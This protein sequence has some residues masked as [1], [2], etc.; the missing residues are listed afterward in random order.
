MKQ[1]TWFLK[2]FGAFCFIWMLFSVADVTAAEH[3]IEQSLKVSGVVSDAQGETLPGVNVFVKGTTIGV[4]TDLDGKFSLNVPSR[5]SILVVSF[6]GYQTNEFIV[7]NTTNFKVVLEEEVNSLEEV[8]VVAYGS[9][10]KQTVTGAVTMMK[11]SE[12]LETPVA[13]V[14]NALTGKL[15]GVITQQPGGRPGEDAAE[16][17]IRGVGTWNDSK[18]L[19]II[20]GIEQ[21]SFAQ[22]DPN[23]IESLSVLKDASS[24]AVYGIRGANGVILITT[25]R[26]NMGK[27]KISLTAN[28]GLQ[29]PTS[30][31]EF[32]GSYE[33]LLLRKK[34]YE[35]DGFD[36]AAEEP[37]RLSAEALEGFRLG[38][39]PYRYPDVNWY[40]EVI[41]KKG[42]LQQQY[43]VN[44]A[45]GTKMVK[46][47]ISVGYLHQNGIF[48]YQDLQDEYDPSVYFKR[49]NFRSNIDLTINKYQTLT[50]NI[51]GRTEEMNG[52]SGAS[53]ANGGVGGFFQG[54]IAKEPWRHPIANPD[55]SIGA[56][57]G[58]TNPIAALSFGG[59]ENSKVNYYDIIGTLKND[60]SFITKGLSLDLSISFNNKYGS[61]KKYS[62]AIDTY[63]YDP[64][65]ERY[66]Q[67][68][69]DSPFAFSKE[70]N[71]SPMRRTNLQL[72]LA[73]GRKF[74]LHNVNSVLVYNQQKTTS[75]SAIPSALMGYAARVEYGYADR[76]LA[77]VSVGYNGSENFAPGHRFGVFPSGSLGY[78]ISEEPFMK[79]AKKFLPYLKIRGSVGLVG[80]DKGQ[81]R[82]LYLGQYDKVNQGSQGG[83]PS[84]GFGTTS[85]STIGGIKETRAGNENLTWET[86]LKS[87]VGIEGRLFKDNLLSF[88][89]DF[90]KEHRKNILMQLNS[91][92]TIIGVAAPY[93]NV[94]E[95]KN[96]GYEVDL[97]HRNKIGNVGYYVKGNYSF[98]RNKVI[99]KDDPVN[100]PDYQKEAGYRIGQY[101]GY[102][103]L[104]FFQSEEEIKHSPDQSTLGGPII[105]GDLKYRD[106]N[107]DNMITEEDKVPIG[108]ARI[109]EIM[110]A[111]TPGIT[112]K[113][114]EISA[115]F[116][117]AANA[118]LFF[119]GNAG[120]EFGGGAGGGQVSKTHQNYW[121]P[122]NPNP[123]Y[124][125]LH[126]NAKHSNKNIN[127]FHLKSGNY[128][129]LKNVSVAYSFPSKI[130][131]KMHMEALKI[132]LNASNLCTWSK[133]DN[134][135]PE[136]VNESGDV[137]PQQ[138]VYNL[139]ININF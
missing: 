33:H 48:K 110:Y 77:E 121:T 137:Y 122:D 13:N 55:G 45:G 2:C 1:K 73:Y 90:F 59:Y 29:V 49:F 70:T 134:F 100:K 24:T 28:W 94:G 115:M 23:E 16:I 30:V 118:S 85:P 6:V 43:N 3:S 71:I 86:A 131:K 133:I 64:I 18:P 52:I 42:S 116:Q 60:L 135:D 51:S 36:P 8:V 88:S 92:P 126:K 11:S 10:K 53:G 35:N 26:G 32:L 84:F 82:F 89:V 44:V 66:D 5:K 119:T 40:D 61:T 139:G 105:P 12:I 22:I 38:L 129:R 65:A 75:G 98:A 87:N 47:F 93:A 102:E 76:Y 108:F 54:I 127:S 19:I 9:Q 46:Y 72:K 132:Y 34:A 63:Y 4:I 17:Y 21:E 106:V 109:P 123:S 41:N 83:N 130:C 25:K 91:V 138:S 39:D 103:V 74:G 15:P 99:Y 107:G 117:G 80:N 67:V 37:T 7:G 96:W 14:T 101:R 104:G 62:D 27:P 79:N 136:M 97:T 50:A 120:F 78:V 128:L 58:S 20:D 124:P 68:T 95:T 57:T 125:S 31:P 69:D 114:F 56:V 81:A 111:V 113:G 112:W